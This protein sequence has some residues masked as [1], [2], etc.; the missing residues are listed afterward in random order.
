MI[1][2]A[3]GEPTT[4]FLKNKIISPLSYKVYKDNKS[5]SSFNFSLILQLLGQNKPTL[6]TAKSAAAD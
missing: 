2:S 3:A 5:T 1:K 6:K 4:G